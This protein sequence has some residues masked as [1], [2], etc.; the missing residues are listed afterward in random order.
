MHVSRF[1]A[2]LGPLA[3]ASVLACG[4]DD[5][6]LPTDE[7]PSSRLP[8]ALVIFSGNSQVGAPGSPLP[9]QV[10]VR[11]ADEV[12]AGL[13][14]QTV[15]WSVATGEGSAT[16]TSTTN[17]DGLA[18]ANWT[19][20]NPGPNTLT[21]TV[22][23]VGSV[24]FTATASNSDG[25]GSGGG[26]TG[27][28]PSAASST[29]SADPATIQVGSGVSS[30]R[31]TVRD[32][33]GAPVPNV[34]VTLS[35][36]G[37]GNTLTQPAA[38]T[39]TDG[40]AVG[41]LK[42]SVVGTKDVTATANGTVQIAQ[43]A[44]VFVAAAPATRV[45]LVDGNNQSAET[46]SE[47]ALPPAV[48]VTNSAGEPVAGVAVTFVVTRGGGSVSG[49]AQTTDAQGLARVGSW[50]LGAEGRNTLEARAGSLAGSPVVFEAT[51]TAPPEPPPMAEP[52]HFVFR[53]QPP[54]VR[55][56][57]WFTVEVAI[58]D[59]SGNIVPLDG[60]EV[61]LGLWEE[62]DPNPPSNNLLAGDRFED[63]VNGIATFN[64]YVTNAGTYRLKA[65]SDYLP[66][67]L[68]P[69]GPELFSRTFEVN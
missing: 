54:D 53:V 36:T 47:V 27:T 11:V 34:V 32:A 10:V 1:S 14:D 60:T 23:G 40:V 25:P 20:G 42:S 45:E 19:L 8:A 41:T 65:R 35:A 50:T 44:Q 29:V 7:T 4:G 66:Q 21:A 58:V 57:E 17:A 61:Y 15:S 51:A 9:Q 33:A 39:G 12:G 31:V 24:T 30:I 3:A 26:G 64:L 37:S 55:V 67:H 69:Y 2:L 68:G 6:V 52:D 28:I 56:G 62:G 18:A 16:P 38:R 43:T 63:T 59:A 46:G 48:R 5:L 49:A 13:A 22:S